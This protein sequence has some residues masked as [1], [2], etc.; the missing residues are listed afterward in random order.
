MLGL[1]NYLCTII[2]CPSTAEGSWVSDW[3]M[4]YYRDLI[5]I[6][7]SPSG[8]HQL[9][10]PSAGNSESW[11]LRSHS[12]P[13]GQ[14]LGIK[15]HQQEKWMLLLSDVLLGYLLRGSMPS[16]SLVHDD[17]MKIKN[18]MFQNLVMLNRFPD[19]QTKKC[20]HSL[21]I[22]AM[23]SF[24]DHVII[25]NEN[26]KFGFFLVIEKNSGTTDVNKEKK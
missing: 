8:L 14:D 22:L 6:Q 13:C 1:K 11:Q 12:F 19:R 5:K 24:N 17:C 7:H 23:C 4:T 16:V 3:Q 21:E 2:Q 26:Q 10:V 25:F 9:E 20:Q 18:K 15:L